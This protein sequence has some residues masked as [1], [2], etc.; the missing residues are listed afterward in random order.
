MQIIGLVH[1]HPHPHHHHHKSGTRLILAVPGREEGRQIGGKSEAL[2]NLFPP[3]PPKRG[4]TGGGLHLESGVRKAA[5][6]G[7]K[8]GGGGDSKVGGGE[9]VPRVA[10]GGSEK[11]AKKSPLS[12]APAPRFLPTCSSLLFFLCPARLLQASSV[13]QAHKTHHGKGQMLFL[14]PLVFSYKASRLPTVN[15]QF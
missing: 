10:P 2:R 8:T 12:P 6:K 15:F 4:A 9:R 11:A 14:F 7:R 5:G 13:L 3:H 1:N